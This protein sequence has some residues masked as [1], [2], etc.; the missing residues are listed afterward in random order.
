MYSLINNLQPILLK[1][2][3]SIIIKPITIKT[4]KTKTAIKAKTLATAAIT[5]IKAKTSATAAI[6][7]KTSAAAASTA[8]TKIIKK[9][10]A[11]TIKAIIT[12]SLKLFPIDVVDIRKDIPDKIRL[13]VNKNQRYIFAMVVFL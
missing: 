12:T 7:A 13:N 4:A 2:L 6:K 9:A 5:A 8:T 10:V 1:T 3:L 11:A